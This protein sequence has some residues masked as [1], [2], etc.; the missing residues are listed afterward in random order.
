MMVRTPLS[1][2]LVVC[3][4][5]LL[6]P[7]TSRSHDTP[8]HLMDGTEVEY[9]YPDEGT[10]VVT[11]RNG[12]VNFLWIADP[13]TGSAGGPHPYRARQVSDEQYFVNWHESDT[14][15]F[16]T[17]FIDI[18]NMRVYGSALLAEANTVIFDEAKI[19]RIER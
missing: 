2:T 19:E 7:L 13:F 18:E 12:G 4:I 1:R 6:G 11:F 14:G 16:V 5:L 17:L 8:S 10:V 15:D 3:L 9:A